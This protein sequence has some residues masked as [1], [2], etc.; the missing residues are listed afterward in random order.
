[1][2]LFPIQVIRVIRPKSLRQ[3]GISLIGSTIEPSQQVVSTSS[4]SGAEAPTQAEPSDEAL[5]RHFVHNVLPNGLFS[6]LNCL[7]PGDELLQV[8]WYILLSPVFGK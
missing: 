5:A 6:N 1:M 7:K 8:R 2:Y 4:Q 3:L